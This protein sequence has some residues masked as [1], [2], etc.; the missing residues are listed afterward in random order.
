VTGVQTCALTIFGPG[1]WVVR[2]VPEPGFG[3]ADRAA[4]LANFGKY[5]SHRLEV[6]V[7]LVDD[8]ARQPSGKYKWVA[9]EW[10]PL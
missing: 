6:S 3:E 7:Q 1:Q 4:L 9:Q 10:R 8:I 2:L 5:I